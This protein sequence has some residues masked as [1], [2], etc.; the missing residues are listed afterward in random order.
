MLI[1][2]CYPLTNYKVT[3]MQK[4]YT[5]NQVAE[6]LSASIHKIRRDRRLGIGPTYIKIGGMV[7]YCPDEIEK[8]LSKNRCQSTSEYGGK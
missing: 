3:K 4:L 6:I 2:D 8:Y 1:I 5:E 7:R